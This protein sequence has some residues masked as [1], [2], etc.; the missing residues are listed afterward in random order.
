MSRSAPRTRSHERRLARRSSLLAGPTLRIVCALF[1]GGIVSA[2]AQ[3]IDSTTSYLQRMDR[4]GDG[5]VSLDEYLA[6]MSYAFDARDLDHDG[7]LSAAELPGGRGPSITRAQHLAT[8]TARFR[9][10][11][12]N[13]DGYLSARELAAPPQ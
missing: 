9:K 3:P 5:R 2:H 13:G 4:D 1:A 12:T 10:Q 8:L 11:D 7:V 6:W